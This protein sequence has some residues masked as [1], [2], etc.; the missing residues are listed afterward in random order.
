VPQHVVRARPPKAE[1]PKRKV[2][3]LNPITLL[4]M[5]LPDIGELL[6]K[7]ASIR[8]YAMTTEW[9]YA[10]HACSLVIFFYPDIATGTLRALKYNATDSRG[11]ARDGSSCVHNILLAR[12]D[13]RR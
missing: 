4:G 9:T 5:A 8:E 10:M 13:D 2:A 1:K 6:G 7:P 11:D 3:A 12:A